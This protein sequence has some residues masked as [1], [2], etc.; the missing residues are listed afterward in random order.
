MSNIKAVLCLYDRRCYLK[1]SLGRTG[2]SKVG[3]TL[4][5]RKIRA[6]KVQLSSAPPPAPFSVYL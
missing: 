3:Y 1:M 4:L 6:L 2:G 5:I